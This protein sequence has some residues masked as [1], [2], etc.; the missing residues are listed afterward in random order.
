[1]KKQITYAAVLGA[2][3]L[4]A[5]SSKEDANEE[6][7]G[8]AISPYLDKEGALCL[9]FKRWPV[10]VDEEDLQAQKT[11]PTGIAAQ[12]AVLDSLGLVTGTKVDVKSAF[13]TKMYKV[14]RYVPTEAGKKF[15]QELKHK[16][17]SYGDPAKEMQGELCY[18]KMALDKVVKWEGPIKLGDYQAATVTYLYK[19][20]NVADWAQKPAFLSA[21]PDVVKTSEEASSKEKRVNVHLTSQGWEVEKGFWGGRP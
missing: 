10:G 19:V 5:C 13:T 18:G 20:E 15:Y 17:A 11:T 21:F 8:A 4:A 7:F 16:M 3:V 6:N 14:T 9:S 1:M 2:L 12:M